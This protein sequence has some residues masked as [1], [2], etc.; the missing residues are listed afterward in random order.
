MGVIIEWPRHARASA[1][2]DRSGAGLACINAKTSKVT[3]SKPR[4]AAITTKGAQYSPPIRPRCAH[5]LIAVAEMSSPS[6]R[7]SSDMTSSEGHFSTT[8]RGVSN[9]PDTLGPFVL[10]VKANTS[11]DFERDF[12][13]ISRMAERM[14]ESEEEAAFIGRVRAARMAR[15]PKQRPL[16]E[17]LRIDQGTW[18]Q[19]E[20]R[21][22]LPRRYIPDFCRATGVSMEW[23]LTGEGEGPV[24][25]AFPAPRKKAQERPRRREFRE[26]G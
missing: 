18:K 12:S 9:M 21:T 24:T 7:K 23:L 17:L 13:Q 6:A 8:A 20:K 5:L 10:N 15:F 11:Y 26:A 2:A 22:P 3:S 19:Y 1:S 14:T 25:L 16:Y 4:R